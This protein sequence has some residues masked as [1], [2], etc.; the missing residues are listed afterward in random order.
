MTGSLPV[1]SELLPRSRELPSPGAPKRGL[2]EV[3]GYDLPRELGRGAT[4]RVY[5]AIN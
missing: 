3:D 1:T 2:P 4:A 5:E